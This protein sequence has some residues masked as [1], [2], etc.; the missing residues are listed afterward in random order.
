MESGILMIVIVV[1]GVFYPVYTAWI[2][3]VAAPVYLKIGFLFA[4]AGALLVMRILRKEKQ[5][6]WI[7]LIGILGAYAWSLYSWYDEECHYQYAR[8]V[9]GDSGNA[10]MLFV[11]T[12]TCLIPLFLLDAELTFW[13]ES[14]KKK[15]EESPESEKETE[16]KENRLA[17]GMKNWFG[18]HRQTLCTLLIC[19]M[20][21]GLLVV[22]LY[23][24]KCWEEGC[25]NLAF[26][27]IYC[28]QHRAEKIEESKREEEE[29]KKRE[30]AELIE[31]QKKKE[32]DESRSHE[33]YLKRIEED[34]LWELKQRSRKNTPAQRGIPPVQKNL[35]NP[36]AA[37]DA[38]YDDVMEGDDYDWDRYRRDSEYADGVDDALDEREEYGRDDW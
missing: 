15:K 19:A 38:G 30:R 17:A 21:C 35:Q 8:S 20:G 3:L 26:D 34:P 10:L 11:G 14:R 6:K 1:I 33:E 22:L 7:V 13:M 2:S 4:M 29:R 37:Y 24:Y 18:K 36:Y 32:E 23:P 27:G 12:F 5:I 9:H 31:L 28:E 25:Y 16:K